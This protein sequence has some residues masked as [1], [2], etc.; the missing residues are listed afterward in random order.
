MRVGEPDVRHKRNERLARVPQ[1]LAAE[2]RATHRAAFDGFLK[3]ERMGEPLLHPLYERLETRSEVRTD[4]GKSAILAKPRDLLPWRL[5][6]KSGQ[7]QK[8]T[9]ASKFASASHALQQ[10][11]CETRSGG[12]EQNT[13]R[14][15]G[16]EMPHLALAAQTTQ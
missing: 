14:S 6:K 9:G 1:K 16:K 2:C 3:Q 15:R 7:F 10:P 8:Q 12:A 13:A 11:E 4:F 5:T